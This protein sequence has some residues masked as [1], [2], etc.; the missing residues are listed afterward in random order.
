MEPTEHKDHVLPEGKW[1]F[2]A[3]VTEVFDE[4]LRRSIPQYDV[5]R[6]TVSEIASRFVEEKTAIVDL[7]CSRGDA[8]DP[9]I[10]KFGAYNRFVGVE[11]SQPMLE[12]ARKRFQGYIDCNVVSIRE[13]DLRRE[14]PPERASVILSVLTLQF[15]PIEYRLKIVREAFNSLIPGGAFILVEKVLGASAEIDDLLVDL[16]YGMKREHGYSQEEIDRKR[17][18]LEGV[19]VPV[20]A[21]WNEQLVRQCGF[22]Q[23]DCFWRYLNF[24]G[25]VAVKS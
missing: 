6:D 2:D 10:R 9:L 13:M 8:L 16:Y 22:S 14:F 3:E 1:A 12:A 18:S 7:G 21:A 23:V 17:L 4:M 11:V 19:L 5:M 24:A 15:T 20:T 25:W